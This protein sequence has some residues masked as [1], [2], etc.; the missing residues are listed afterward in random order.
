MKVDL[1]LSAG[2]V[3]EYTED[4]AKELPVGVS[5]A[6]LYDHIN[7]LEVATGYNFGSV[8]QQLKIDCMQVLGLIQP[9]EPAEDKENKSKEV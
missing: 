9:E 7:K 4:K 1:S 3:C 8:V 6:D 2:L 5:F